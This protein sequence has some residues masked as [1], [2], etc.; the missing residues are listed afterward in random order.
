MNFD[1]MLQLLRELNRHE[2]DYVLVGGVAMI[3]HGIV[4]MTSD[5]DLFVRPEAANIERLRTALR[6]L[7]DDPAIAEIRAE[8]LAGNFPAVRY[9]PPEAD[10]AMDF[11]SRIGIGFRF[12]DLETQVILFDGVPLTVAT[13]RQLNLM[14][15]D[16]VR[17][18]DHADAEVLREHFGL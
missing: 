7:W 9:V 3:V 11:F 17:L 4:R 6:V 8:D 16:T 13:P 2:V 5:V 12:E 15:K 18:Y 1:K 10:V 14:K